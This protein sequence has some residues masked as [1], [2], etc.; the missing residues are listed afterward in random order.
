MGALLGLWRTKEGRYQPDAYRVAFGL[1]LTA[2]AAAALWLLTAR[3]E[4]R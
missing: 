3:Q 4:K 2:Q 1:L